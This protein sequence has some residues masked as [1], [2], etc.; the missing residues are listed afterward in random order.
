MD[1][2]RLHYL[3]GKLFF[4]GRHVPFDALFNA[5]AAGYQKEYL[6]TLKYKAAGESEPGNAA[7]GAMI[8]EDS[9]DP[10]PRITNALKLRAWIRDNNTPLLSPKER[11]AMSIDQISL[12]MGHSDRRD[13]RSRRG[14]QAEGYRER[15]SALI[16]REEQTRNWISAYPLDGLMTLFND[17]VGQGKDPYEKSWCR[18]QQ[19]ALLIRERKSPEQAK[20][21]MAGLLKDDRGGVLLRKGDEQLLKLVS[22]TLETR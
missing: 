21:L 5:A 14:G 4:L 20:G 2:P 1:N 8:K 22:T 17:C 10:P 15:L 13:I 9:P 18:L 16:S 3:A 11:D 6:L 7:L 12:I 19:A